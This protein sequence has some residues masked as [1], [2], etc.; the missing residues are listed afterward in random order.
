M[1]NT[2]HPDTETLIAYLEQSEASNLQPVGLHLA[3][4]GQCRKELQA[5]SSLRQHAGWIST[6][7]NEAS[8]DIS[9]EV[10]DLVHNRLSGQQAAETRDRIVQNPA[11]LRQALHYARHHAAM[12]NQVKNVAT[13]ASELSLFERLRHRITALLQFETP[14]WKL[15]PVAVVLVAIVAVFNGVAFEPASPNVAKI[16]QFEDQNSIQFV[17]QESQPGIGFFANSVRASKPFDGVSVLLKNNREIVF[18]WPAIKDAVSYRLKLQVFRNG[19]IV[20]LG[21]VSS[22]QPHALIQL[23]EAPGQHRY[24]WVITGDTIKGQSFQARGGFVVTQ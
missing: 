6:D 7:R 24:E 12:K 22:K 10:A 16:V 5:L 18:D 17:A 3:G 2:K 4:C 9:V 21:R 14:V 13:T 20:V 19:E 8:A 15:I 23:S 11:S 1:T